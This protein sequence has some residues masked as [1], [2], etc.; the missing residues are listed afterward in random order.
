MDGIKDC[1]ETTTAMED[2]IPPRRSMNTINSV[3][4]YI[5]RK[6]VGVQTETYTSIDEKLDVIIE[7]TKIQNSKVNI[8][9][10]ELS[11]VVEKLNMMRLEN[12]NLRQLIDGTINPKRPTLPP[13][14][15]LHE[16]HELAH[17][18]TIVGFYNSSS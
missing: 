8:L 11:T 9:E 17:S 5:S 2:S 15:T 18:T 7:Y 12:K 16:L 14:T 1:D 4:P 10:T 3:I 6:D 13:A